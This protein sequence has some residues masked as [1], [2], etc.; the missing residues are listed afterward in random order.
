VVAERE[1][2]SLD[3]LIAL[4]VTVRD[5]LAAKVLAVLIVTGAVVLP[6][7]AVNAA[8][9]LA[10][11]VIPPVHAALLAL[12]LLGALVG[13]SGVAFVITLVAR[14]F[15]AANNLS[16]ILTGPLLL[17]IAATLGLIPGYTRLVVVAAGLA[18]LGALCLVA[19]ARWITFER[20]L[21]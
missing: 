3:L 21:S 8:M 15:R 17:A 18:V 5:I 16:G 20:Y 2:R 9:M 10:Q 13:S 19:A 6:L 14:D 12:V 7:F 4:P 11:G 1:R